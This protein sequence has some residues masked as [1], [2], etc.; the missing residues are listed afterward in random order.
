LDLAQVVRRAG[1]TVIA[2]H[3]RGSWGSAGK[4]TLAGGVDD[5]HA[6]IEHLQDPAKAAAWG[7]DP[8]RIVLMGHSYGGYIAARAS[9]GVP[10]LMGVALI[11]PWDG[12]MDARA[13]TPLTPARRKAEALAAFDD[14]DGRLGGVTAVS[15]M[16]E[17]M[18]DG[19]ALDLARLA[20]SLAQL[21]LLLITATRDSDDDKAAGLLSELQRLRARELTTTTLDSDHG[22]NSQRI[23]LEVE[24]LRWL[25]PLPGAPPPRP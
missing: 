2:F 9:D 16:D 19:S 18:R 25:A 17:V 10:G 7:V 15:L 4:F 6:L 23:A 21:R 24:V 22:F 14:V 3:Y 11:A 12:S 20:P 8:K 5:A 13:W 1:W